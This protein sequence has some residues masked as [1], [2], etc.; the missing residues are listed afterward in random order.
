MMCLAYNQE[1]T[2]FALREPLEAGQTWHDAGTSIVQ[3]SW[4]DLQR[5]EELYVFRDLREVRLF[6]GEHPYL[7]PILVDSYVKIGEYFP[8]SEI[9]LGVYNNPEANGD[10]ELVAYIATK[11]PPKDAVRQLRQL[12]R[13]WALDAMERAR[14]NLRISIEIL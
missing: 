4:A 12:G 5:L 2:R 1:A 11:L 6:L 3:P 7:I 14:G 8:D 9:F 13:D 10:A